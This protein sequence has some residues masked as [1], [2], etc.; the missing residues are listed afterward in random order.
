MTEVCQAWASDK[1]LYETEMPFLRAKQNSALYQFDLLK[2]EC[3]KNFREL[4]C[5]NTEDNRLLG[6]WLD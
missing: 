2:Y 5:W 4:Q 3:F 1:G 6:K